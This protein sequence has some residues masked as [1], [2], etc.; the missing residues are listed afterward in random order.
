MWAVS[1]AAAEKLQIRCVQDTSVV[2]IKPPLWIIDI[3]N[4]C[5]AFSLNIYIP[6]KSE[7]TTTLQSL[8][9]SQFFQKFNLVCANISTF[10][11]FQNM[12]ITTLTPEEEDMLG[13]KVHKLKPMCMD[14]F[15]QKLT[16]IDED[17]PLT[18]PNWLQLTLQIGSGATLLTV[19]GCVLWFCIR[20]RSHL[21]ALLKFTSTLVTKLKENLIYSHI[22]YQ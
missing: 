22:C 7:L 20:H 8:P 6:A 18:L 9:H 10:V 13:S 12:S 11:V 15:Q 4:G 16:L 19:G 1:F 2:T 14:L 3:G 17:Y 5:E 21:V